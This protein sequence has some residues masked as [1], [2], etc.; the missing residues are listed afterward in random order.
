V[1]ENVDLIATEEQPHVYHPGD[2]L[3]F[4]QAL[5]RRIQVSAESILPAF[6]P[7][8]Q[9]NDETPDEPAGYVIPLR[10]RQFEGHLFWSSQL[11]FP[12]P[13]RLELAPGDSPIGYRIPVDA[14][15]WVAPDEIVY[16]YEAEPFADRVKLPARSPAP[17]LFSQMPVP[18]PLPP[19]SRTAE[20]ATQQIRPAFCVE[21]REGRLHVFLPYASVAADF[22]DLVA[23]LEE[24]CARLQ[25]PIWIEGYSAP[26]DPRLRAFSLTPDP[27]V[28]EVNLPPTSNWD[29]LERLNAIL[30]EEAT[31]NRLTALKFGFNGSRLATGGGS[32]IVL[33]GATV[34]DSPILRRPDL[35]RSMLAFWQNHPSLSFLFSGLYVGPTS[36]YPRVDEARADALYELEVA[37]SQLSSDCA[38]E[39]LDG[40]FRNL[41]VD[42]TGN[43]H[44]AEFCIDK[45]YPPQ[46]AGLRAGL[47]ELRAFEM[48]PHFRMGLLEML[49]VRALVCAFWK[50]PFN[51]S[52]IRWGGALHDRFMLPHFV[53]RDFAE[54]LAFLGAAGFNFDEAW[55]V[56]HS[57]FR[58]PL[59]GTIGSEGVELELR[60]AL[61]PWNVLAE[62]SMSGGT[63]RSV[64][65]S[66]E[67]IQ[68]KVSGQ[69]AESRYVVACNG[70]R[71]PLHPTGAAES[72]AGIR[73]RAR[74]LNAALHP[75]I[76]V[77]SPLTFDLID[78]WRNASVVRC[79]YHSGRPDGEF[80]PGRP[81]DA[82]EAAARRGERFIVASPPSGPFPAPGLESNPVFPMTLDMR[83]PS[84]DE[85]AGK[86]RKIEPGAKP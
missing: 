28:L 26:F 17:H 34:P 13:E 48:A 52:L 86:T 56:P 24:T 25:M 31:Q 30:F 60:Q 83:W 4:L 58:F 62:D 22:L 82:E 70:R 6:N 64:D 54:V 66:L 15:P 57:D 53:Q 42:V 68:I 10:R 35:L 41:L 1:W 50:K 2:A 20:T 49:L 63:V 74:K 16:E 85:M 3:A 19:L 40:L 55:F 9:N 46:G 65:S 81:A 73:F 44:R 23:A 27:G 12:R 45:L 59:I 79:I 69:T 18:D 5:S 43:T 78:T 38:P 80:Y 11:W 14:M 77:H 39:E 21:V 29:E 71:V 67:R 8:S 72:V 33:G 32:H 76:P 7:K 37:F 51:G 75:T 84:P 61:E 47:L 36:Q